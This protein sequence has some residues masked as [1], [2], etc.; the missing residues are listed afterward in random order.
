ME[1]WGYFWPF[2]S[3]GVQH[4]A[5]LTVFSEGV[6]HGVGD[7]V[8]LRGAVRENCR[9]AFSTSEFEFQWECTLSVKKK[10]AESDE[11]FASD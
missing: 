8:S 3:E 10:S 11:I 9:A 4:A 1:Y 7:R 5:I 6:Q 2:F